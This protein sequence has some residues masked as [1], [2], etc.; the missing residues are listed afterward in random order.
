LPVRGLTV[1]GEHPI[2]VADVI[3]IGVGSMTNEIKP[4]PEWAL[5]AVVKRLH[6]KTAP[7]QPVSVQVFVTDD[8]SANELPAKAQEI[9]DDASA[10]LNLAPDAVRIG[11]I[12]RLAKSFS[13]TSDIPHVFDA[14]AKRGE[15]KTIL[16]SAQTDVLPK[17]VKRKAVP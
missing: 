3:Q 13:I 2:W 8:V 14:I 4:S 17:P 1:G 11:K 7:G 5:E 16:E 10:S 6:E 12:H 9:V 15:V